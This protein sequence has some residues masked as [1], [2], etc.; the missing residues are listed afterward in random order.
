ME[1][2]VPLI[3]NRRASVERAASGHVVL[4]DIRRAWLTRIGEDEID[5][6]RK[7][8]TRARAHRIT[9]TVITVRPLKSVVP[10]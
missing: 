1:L 6:R 7:L 9:K 10:A 4:S 5:R 3:Q 2:V 8:V